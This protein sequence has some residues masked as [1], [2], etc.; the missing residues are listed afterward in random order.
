MQSY[1]EDGSMFIALGVTEP[2]KQGGNY[3]NIHVPLWA[4]LVDM[5]NFSWRAMH[6]ALSAMGIVK[7]QERGRYEQE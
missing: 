2:L 3:S 4:V 1:K 6:T 5:N 7:P